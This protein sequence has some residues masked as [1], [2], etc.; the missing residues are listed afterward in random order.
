MLHPVAPP[1]GKEIFSVLLDTIFR[2]KFCGR[3]K[4][5]NAILVR[6]EAENEYFYLELTVDMPLS[7]LYCGI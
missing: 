2:L 5:Y 3:Y 4:K 6:S 7:N 1:P